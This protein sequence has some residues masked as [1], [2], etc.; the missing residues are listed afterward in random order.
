MTL[1]KDATVEPEAGFGYVYLFGLAVFDLGGH[2]L[3]ST[4][5]VIIQGAGQTE[6]TIKNGTVQTTSAEAQELIH[7]NDKCELYLEDVTLVGPVSDGQRRPALYAPYHAIIRGNSTFIGGVNLETGQ[8][9]YELYSGTFTTGAAAGVTPNSYSIF[10]QDGTNVSIL[11]LL[12]GSTVF[13]NSAGDVINAA[14]KCTWITVSKNYQGYALTEDVTIVAHASH[15]YDPATGQCLCGEP[16]P[17]ETLYTDNDGHTEGACTICG[18]QAAIAK[19]GT[20]YYRDIAA[21]NEA[22]KGVTGHPTLTILCDITGNLKLVKSELTLEA[23]S[24][25]IN[26]ALQVNNSTV[27]IQ[28]GTYAKNAI[29]ANSVV[30][31]EG[32][33]YAG[34]VNI[35]GSASNMTMKGSTFQGTVAMRGQVTVTENA[36]FNNTVSISTGTATVENASFTKA[37]T[38]NADGNLVVKGGTLT[39]ATVKA[40]GSAHFQGGSI[41]GTLLVETDG[42]LTASAGSF[43]TVAFQTGGKGVLSGGYYANIYTGGEALNTKLAAGYA[44]FDQNG[45]ISGDY[46]DGT[47][48]VAIAS[49][50]TV[51]PHSHDFRDFHERKLCGCGAQA[52]ATVTVGETVS[53]Y[54]TIETALTAAQEKEGCTLTLLEGLTENIT[55]PGGRFTL[56][57]ANREST[58]R[59]SLSGTADVT[60]KNSNIVRNSS[61]SATRLVVMG[62]KLTVESGTIYNADVQGDGEAILKGGTIGSLFN[63]DGTITVP[64]SSTLRV[65]EKLSVYGGTVRLSGGYYSKITGWNS[66]LVENF[67]AEGYAYKRANTWPAYAGLKEIRDVSVAYVPLQSIAL[68]L[69]AGEVDLTYGYQ[70]GEAPQAAASVV[71]NGTASVTYLW[72]LTDE[73][74]TKTTL[75]ST[76][77]TGTLPVGLAAGS[78]Q[79]T[80]TATCEGY[81]LCSAPITITVAKAAPALTRQPA[82]RENL[83]YCFTEQTLITAGTVTGGEWQYSLNREE[84]Y[85]TALPTGTDAGQ[86]T[87]WYKVVGDANHLDTEPASLQV[88][89]V[90]LVVTAPRILLD[91]RCTYNGQPQRPAVTLMA[92][93]THEIPAEEYTVEYGSNINAGVNTATVTI[94]DREN[95]NFTVSGSGSFSIEKAAAPTLAPLSLTQKYT[96]TT[97]H[98]VPRDYAALMPQD[99]GRIFYLGGNYMVP[100]G[101]TLPGWSVNAGDGTVTYRLEGATAEMVGQTITIPV[102]IVSQNYK[103]A[104]AQLVITLLDKD[105]PELSAEGIEMI[106]TGSAVPLERLTETAAAR[107][108]GNEIDGHWR[109]KNGSPTNVNESGDYYAVFEPEDTVN[110]HSAEIKVSI[111]ILPRDIAEARIVLGVAL[112]YTGRQQR[113][114]ITSVTLP[115]Y[116]EVTYRVEG[117]TAADAGNYELVVSGTDNFTGSVR[118]GYTVARAT[119][120]NVSVRQSGTLTYNGSAQQAAVTADAHAAGAQEVTFTY[121]TEE[122]GPYGEMPAFTGAGRYTVYYR[123]EAANHQPATGHFTITIDRLD[124]SEAAIVWGPM[125]V[126]T[127]SAQNVPITAIKA[128]GLTLGAGDYT[129][130]SGGSG[131]AAGDYRLKIAGAGNFTGTKEMAWKIEKAAQNLSAPTVHGTYGGRDRIALEGAIGTVTHTIT[132]GEGV[133]ALDEQNTITFLRAGSASILVKAAGDE[134]HQAAEI[135]VAVQVEK[136]V[137]VIKAQ[138]KKIYVGS[139]APDLTQAI[140]GTDYIIDGLVTGDI[141]EWLDIGIELTY[142]VTP[143]TTKP[144]QYAIR[145]TV[146]GHNACY[147]FVCEDGT[148][149]VARYPVPA[150]TWYTIRTTTGAHGT[151]SPSGWVSVR[152][153]W[154][155]TFTITP[156]EGYTV[157]AVRVD[158]KYVGAGREYTFRQVSKDHTIEV[159][160]RKGTSNPGTG[161][162]ESETVGRGTGA[163]ISVSL[164]WVAAD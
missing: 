82:G 39:S 127:G 151:I 117:D 18:K 17:H 2:T 4:G 87:V 116:R 98:T 38:V 103:D 24:H 121:S 64:G 140:P 99:A 7:Q 126:Y 26:G 9:Y 144:G 100:S 73:N 131:T 85:S 164:Q 57:M 33:D 109:W 60:L 150:Y 36:V 153:G 106:Y 157:A 5:M 52:V 44:Y 94:K 53:Y 74:N 54:E 67:L 146:L 104:T 118:V 92:D 10:T 154:D 65:S 95:G 96:D 135:T 20:T 40:N 8:G 91:G 115:G 49:G 15:T 112:T 42:E 89:I 142:P 48:V 43:G 145:P 69:T 119:L 62:G 61:D 110:F 11:N 123:A 160:F 22:A 111:T 133:I 51:A 14:E 134:N 128:G 149:T 108:D 32:G 41:S 105:T 113:Q 56:D 156:D 163:L 30:T 19:I 93:A 27:T 63:H 47:S 1:L 6:L 70:A 132:A 84:G 28:G 152:E 72:E 159:T 75:S 102:I 124:L 34:A 147:E 31:L 97:Q 143:D 16:C 161:A 35:S 23:G 59:L 29:F 83:V 86:Y 125:P 78:Y 139:A 101:V 155:Q 107:W 138:D 90:P 25:T 46:I 71:Q 45:L 77:G 81:S 88:V 158:G 76:T 137:A 79:L 148:L 58:G 136:A 130:V 13:A 162:A 55:I 68:R 21:L 12:K 37:V 129:V 3:T 114:E 80:C 50:V 122:N 141:L 120:E 66:T